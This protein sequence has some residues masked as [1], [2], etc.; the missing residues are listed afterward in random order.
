[1]LRYSGYEQC[2]RIHLLK[3]LILWLWM[4]YRL[5]GNHFVMYA[6]VVRYVWLLK[7]LAVCV[8]HVKYVMQHRRVV[9]PA[10]PVSCVCLTR[11]VAKI[12]I[13]ATLVLVVR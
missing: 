3:R 7:P 6:L 1:M 11:E 9:S 2:L 10:I 12:V 5:L 4:I 8:I 13:P